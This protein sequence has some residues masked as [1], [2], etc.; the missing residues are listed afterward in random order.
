MSVTCGPAVTTVAGCHLNSSATLDLEKLMSKVCGTCTLCC[1]LMYILELEKPG[2]R[3][4]QH[5]TP[6]KGCNIYDAKPRSCSDFMCL[7]LNSDLPDEFRPDKI[8][9]VAWEVP[10]NADVM[11]FRENPG[12]GHFPRTDIV[13]QEDPAFYPTVG[14]SR[15]NVKVD[16]LVR[17][18][19]SLGE[20]VCFINRFERSEV[21][22]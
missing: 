7:W 18:F 16:Q 20:S 1:K 6:G 8:H 9:I 17:T 10:K 3:W 4:C 14:S 11:S 5:C 21:R 2:N 15:T 22:P 13:I 12:L 19:L